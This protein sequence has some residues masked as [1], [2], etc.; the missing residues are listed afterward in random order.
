MQVLLVQMFHH[1]AVSLIYTQLSK[2][3]IVIIKVHNVMKI[4]VLSVIWV[5]KFCC[6]KHLG[7]NL[8]SGR[9]ESILAVEYCSH[10]TQSVVIGK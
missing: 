8:R 4:V 3:I 1:Q 5:R 7:S 6:W 10:S 2:I 9:L